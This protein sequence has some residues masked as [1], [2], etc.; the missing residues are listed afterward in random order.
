MT[1]LIFTISEKIHGPV[2]IV[3]IGIYTIGFYMLTPELSRHFDLLWMVIFDFVYVLGAVFL[4]WQI[5]KG[6]KAEMKQ[7]SEIIQLKEEMSA[8]E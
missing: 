3:L 5:G 7:L 2:T 4:I 6:I 1:P 8:K